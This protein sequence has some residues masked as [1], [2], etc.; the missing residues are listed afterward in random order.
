M[1]HMNNKSKGLSITTAVNIDKTHNVVSLTVISLGNA[2]VAEG[3]NGEP[4]KIVDAYNGEDQEAG[5]DGR[6]RFREEVKMP[7]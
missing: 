3:A 4:S 5:S 2:G 6:P 1:Q 7:P